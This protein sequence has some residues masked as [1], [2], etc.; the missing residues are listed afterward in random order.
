MTLSFGIDYL[1]YNLQI[2][3]N[4]TYSLTLSFLWILFLTWNKYFKLVKNIEIAIALNKCVTMNQELWNFYA[5][6]LLIQPFQQPY[7]VFVCLF[8]VCLF[9]LILQWWD[10]DTKKWSNC[11]RSHNSLSKRTSGFEFRKSGSRTHSASCHSLQPLEY[12]WTQHP[13]LTNSNIFHNCLQ[14]FYVIKTF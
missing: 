5:K 13:H 12:P 3:Y 7:T 2:Y 4:F 1:D 14:S 9:F 6:H 11:P 8:F 10:L